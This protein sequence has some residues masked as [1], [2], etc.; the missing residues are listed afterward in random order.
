MI[1]ERRMGTTP[2]MVEERV[3][4]LIGA[5]EKLVGGGAQRVGGS[6]W[7]YREKLSRGKRVTAQPS[8]DVHTRRRPNNG[9]P[10][11]YARWL[12]LHTNFSH[13]MMGCR[14]GNWSFWVTI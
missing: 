2:R 7:K 13:H 14:T 1:D 11:N 6:R 10:E 9:T 4:V 5:R 3:R 8:W 12:V